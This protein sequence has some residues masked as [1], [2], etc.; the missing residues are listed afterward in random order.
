M[1]VSRVSTFVPAASGARFARLRDDVS[2]AAAARAG[3]CVTICPSGV[4]RAVRAMPLPPQ[5]SQGTII[6]PGSAPLPLQASH[7]AEPVEDDLFG[8]SA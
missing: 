3:D 4:W 8:R 7:G 2:F 1:T 6:V 5:R